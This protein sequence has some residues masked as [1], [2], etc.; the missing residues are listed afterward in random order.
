[1]EIE[2]KRRFPTAE[3]FAAAYGAHPE[4]FET[5]INKFDDHGSGF[6][7]IID[8]KSGIYYRLADSPDGGYTIQECLLA[9]VCAVD[10]IFEDLPADGTQFLLPTVAEGK[11]VD[12]DT[13]LWFVSAK[14]GAVNE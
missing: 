5:V 8:M 12:D 10:D 6:G 9:A 13:Y 14:G 2:T 7:V 4:E 3:L 1:M 11:A